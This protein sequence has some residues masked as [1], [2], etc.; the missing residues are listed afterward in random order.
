MVWNLIYI[1]IANLDLK[2]TVY[3]YVHF[4]WIVQVNTL[5][6]DR[7]GPYIIKRLIYQTRD[8]RKPTN[9]VNELTAAVHAV[10]FSGVTYFHSVHRKR[11]WQHICWKVPENFSMSCPASPS[12]CKCTSWVTGRLSLVLF[13]IS[14]PRGF[15]LQSD[16]VTPSM[17]HSPHGMKWLH[18][19]TRWHNWSLKPSVSYIMGSGVSQD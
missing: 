6:I 18:V 3:S 7:T 13:Q 8:D 2:I 19:T 14:T 11:C 5:N 17:T 15:L 12:A 16:K 1:S 10:C 4:K 9:C